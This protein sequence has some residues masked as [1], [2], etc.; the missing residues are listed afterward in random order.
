MQDEKSQLQNK[1]K[2]MRVLRARIYEAERERQQAELSATRKSQIGSGE[3]AEKIRTYN[4]P[5]SRAT[6]HRVKVTPTSRRCCRAGWTTSPKRCRRRTG[7][8]R[9]GMS[10]AALSLGDVLRRASEHLGKTSET[11]RLDAELLLAHTLG[12]HRIELYTDFDRPLSSQ[13][14]DAYREARGAASRRASRSPTSWASG[15]SAGSR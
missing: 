6:D 13:E 10:T 12:R 5:D 15:A 8:G 2:A 1:A 7:A 9:S 4:Y 11:G 3:R 14:L